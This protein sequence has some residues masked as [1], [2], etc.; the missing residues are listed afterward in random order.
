MVRVPANASRRGRGAAHVGA[1]A[2]LVDRAF[3]DPAMSGG[4][5][6]L[7]LT[8]MAIVSNALFLQPTSHPKPLFTTRASAP[9]PATAVPEVA[10]VPLPRE[11]LAP[12]LAE[13]AGD[14]APEAASAPEQ[15]Q[16]VVASVEPPAPAAAAAPDPARERIVTIQRELAR[17][18]L[19]SGAIDG[20]IGS[21]TRAA[22]SRYQAAAGLAVNGEA[23]DEV[24]RLLTAPTPPADLGPGASVRPP[25]LD[26]AAI[27]RD[28]AVAEEAER[29]RRV[30]QALN[31]IGYGPLSVDGKGGAETVSAI[32]R[33]QLD[34]GLAIDGAPSDAV[35][36]RLV[37]IGALDSA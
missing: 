6:V 26:I 24:V 10:I 25:P 4:L 21:R 13:L 11:R 23:S 5:F 27:E 14:G 17:L 2:R 30:Q 9:A 16:S 19:Y 37:D 36:S 34:S 22:I 3:D 7:T 32:R 1:V 15:T 33:F 8:V 18:G 35:I 12:A 31:K 20:I 28:N 29:Y